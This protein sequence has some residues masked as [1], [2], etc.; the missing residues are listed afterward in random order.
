MRKNLSES[1]GEGYP[2][3]SVQE[4]GS[5]ALVLVRLHPKGYAPKILILLSE[6]VPAASGFLLGL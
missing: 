1:V 3:R 4:Y 2:G 5:L 6:V